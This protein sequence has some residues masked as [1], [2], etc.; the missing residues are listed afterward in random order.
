[1]LLF[2]LPVALR[3][4]PLAPGIGLLILAFLVRV[5]APNHIYNWYSIHPGQVPAE[6]FDSIAP[7]FVCVQELLLLILPK[8]VALFD[9]VALLVTVASAFHAPLV[10]RLARELG[11]SEVAAGFAGGVMALWP[12]LV[13][14]GASD[15]QH[16]IALTFWLMGAVA[17]FGHRTAPSALLL[18]MTSILII[19][20]RFEAVLWPLAWLPL[21]F[22]RGDREKSGIWVRGLTIFVCVAASLPFLGEL[23][24]NVES[25]IQVL[26]YLRTPVYVVQ[27]LT[28]FRPLYLLIN[29]VVALGIGVGLCRTPRRTLVVLAML[30][31]L[32]SPNLL[33]G[34]VPGDP[35]T[36]RYYLPVTVMLVLAMGFL[37]EHTRTFARGVGPGL[38]L[39]SLVVTMAYDAHRV[40]GEEEQFVYRREFNFL[41]NTAAA[42]EEGARLCMIDPRL[43]HSWPG[44]HRD[45]D[46]SFSPV[47]DGMDRYMGIRASLHPLHDDALIATGCDL[48]FESSICF[49]V[50]IAVSGKPKAP[51]DISKTRELCE[52]IH[53][54]LEPR[55]LEQIDVNGVTFTIPF[56]RPRIPLRV[57]R[58]KGKKR[59]EESAG[60][61]VAP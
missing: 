45:L 5:A 24:R 32:S 6:A 25:G 44:E 13:L 2:S 8:S 30:A 31:I 51:Q 49:L 29:L 20:T 38:L 46:T 1:V 52:R 40:F 15:A 58:V 9:A 17:L 12:V 59:R 36:V 16:P 56:E 14:M 55:P 53:R 26:A 54:N 60:E 35:L 22:L 39:L 50:P 43:N 19:A 37:V 21:L 3:A 33:S 7:A 11:L 48:Y 4:A 34:K 61:R 47:G 23:T 41:R 42:A 28:Q 10:Y 57:Y 18:A 27:G